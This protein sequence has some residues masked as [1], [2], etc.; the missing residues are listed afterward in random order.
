MHGAKESRD[1]K[2]V[3]IDAEAGYSPREER[4]RECRSKPTWHPLLF[5]GDGGVL[6]EGT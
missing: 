6:Q 2:G 4:E 1:V 3:A 5:A